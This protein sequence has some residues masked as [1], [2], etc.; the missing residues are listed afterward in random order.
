VKDEVRRSPGCPPSP[1]KR[2]EGTQPGRDP[3]I[4]TLDPELPYQKSVMFPPVPRVTLLILLLSFI[5]APRSIAEGIALGPRPLAVTPY[6]IY[7]RDVAHVD[8]R[9]LAVW[10]EQMGLIPSGLRAAVLD[11]EGRLLSPAFEMLPQRPET[12]SLV[13]VG[14]EFVLF[15]SD[16]D[17]ALHMTR[18]DREGKRI[19]QRTLAPRMPAGE[20]AWNGSRFLVASPYYGYLFDADGAVVSGPLTLGDPAATVAREDGFVVVGGSSTLAA[21]TI[22]NDGTVVTAELD[23]AIGPGRFQKAPSDPRVALLPNGDVLAVWRFG[24]YYDELLELRSSVIRRDGSRAKVE[25]IVRTPE[26]LIVPR[27]L[28]AGGGPPKLLLWWGGKTQLLD[29]DENGLPTSRPPRVL[30]SALW[31]PVADDGEGGALLLGL[32]ESLRLAKDGTVG[33]ATTLATL[34]TRQTQ[35]IL[36]SGGSRYVAVWEEGAGGSGP[37]QSASLSR[38]GSPLGHETIGRSHL[39][40]EELA[41]SGTE[42]LAVTYANGELL[43]L[44]I[45]A[46]GDLIGSPSVLAS[47]EWAYPHERRGAVTTWLGT[48]WAVVWPQNGQLVISFVSRAGVTT[49]PRVLGVRGEYPVPVALAFDGRDA[50]LVWRDSMQTLTLRAV[51]LDADG[52]PKGEAVALPLTATERF[53]VATGG[54]EF[55][56]VAGA[57]AV[58]L[59]TR[60]GQPWVIAERTFRGAGDVAWDGREYVLAYR[61]Q[62]VRWT[63]EIVR[64]DGALRSVS[65]PVFVYTLAP[66]AQLPPSVVADAYASAIVGVQEGDA[67]AGARAVVYREDQ[68]EPLPALPPAPLSVRLTPRD[69]GRYELTWEAAPDASV[70]GYV[71]EWLQ[72]DGTSQAIRVLGAEARSF[73]GWNSRIR[74]RAANPAGLSE[75]PARRRAVR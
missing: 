75:V 6:E 27:H 64:F 63:L 45:D 29:L 37:L 40:A 67:I 7:G 39:I 72:D 26:K 49:E 44:R 12:F 5:A 17:E 48:R 3:E 38:D 22:G 2:G 28:I 55:I 23:Y 42:Y 65:D 57:N 54:D 70:D 32:P 52:L 21:H 46:D 4:P 66:D 36:G 18:F 73:I 69:D 34:P 60:S 62:L 61:R 1:R 56:F 58:V 74:V 19:G 33:P 20:A 24:W 59:E 25:V 43:A 11:E 13:A 15:W 10:I 8:G 51:V 31:G 53:S 47:E 9:F 71:I 68:F 35:P 30:S 16:V 50:L 41:W 14:N